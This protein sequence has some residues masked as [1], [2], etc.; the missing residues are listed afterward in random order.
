MTISIVKNGTIARTCERCVHDIEESLFSEDE[1]VLVFDVDG[2][3]VKQIPTY[4]N[5]VRGHDGYKLDENAIKV[6]EAAE[7]KVDHVVLWSKFPNY[8][9]VMG[10]KIFNKGPYHVFGS[11]D[12]KADS[13]PYKPLQI[14]NKNL[15]NIVGI[16]DNRWFYPRDRV[17]TMHPGR[18][19]MSALLE[20]LDKI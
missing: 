16:E 2:V 5:G 17:V 4:F 20:A 12:R 8:L 15:R 11:F 1:N 13:E 18:N 3:V 9:T 7:K 14:I 19:L 10:R 6:I